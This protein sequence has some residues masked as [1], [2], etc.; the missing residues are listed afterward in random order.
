MG[1][2]DKT[3]TRT[4]LLLVVGLALLVFGAGQAF[5]SSITYTE[6]ATASG[7]IG[8][9]SFFDVFVTITMVG[10]ATNVI[11]GSGFFQNSGTMTIDIPG[12]GLATFTGNTAVFDN[13]GA[14]TVG[15]ADYTLG[16]SILDTVDGAFATYDLMTPIGP[17]TNASFYRPDLTYGTTLGG[18][19]FT[20]MSD[21][22]FT[23]STVPEPSSLLLLGT[24]ALGLAGLIRRKLNL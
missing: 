12:I 5:A 21:S 15:M 11:G 7:T 14:A 22:T 18:L 17:I 23:A 19:N 4:R 2:N 24:G 16:G 3:M 6:Q 20:Q 10:D 9:S 13:Q 8:T 1:G